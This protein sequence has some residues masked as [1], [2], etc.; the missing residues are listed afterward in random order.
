[1]V[2][3][4]AENTK[5]VLLSGS[6]RM[7]KEEETTLGHERPPKSLWSQDGIEEKKE[8]KARSSVQVQRGEFCHQERD[9]GN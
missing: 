1:M 5:E 3:S 8:K 2:D 9:K 6:V 7:S 4:L